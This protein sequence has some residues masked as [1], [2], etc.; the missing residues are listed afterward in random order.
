[1]KVKFRKWNC[2]TMIGW[3]ENGNLAIQLISTRD[4]SPVAIATTN[5]GKNL[6]DYQVAIKDWSENWGM[7]EALEEAGVIDKCIDYEWINLMA[8]I[9]APIYTISEEFSKEVKKEIKKR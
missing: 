7:V 3:Y 4:G 1:M 5:T 8:G 6:P 9:F 2:V